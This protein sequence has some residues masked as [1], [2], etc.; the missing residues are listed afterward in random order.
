[1]KSK[2][3]WWPFIQRHKLRV[4]AIIMMGLLSSYCTLLLPLS[5]G[6][7]MEITA[8]GGAGKTKALHLLGI[9]LPDNLPAFFIFFFVVLIIKFISNWGYCFLA[10]LLGE[11]FAAALQGSL[12]N[13][14]LRR[15]YVVNEGG[16]K[17]SLL[18][19]FT[20]DAKTIQLLLT[21]GI[22][23]FVSDFLFFIM[24]LYVLFRLQPMLTLYVIM[25]ICFF[26]GIQ[27]LYNHSNKPLFAEKRKRQSALLNATSAMLNN[28]NE[29]TNEQQNILNRKKQK[30]KSTL[31]RFHIRK[32]FLKALSPFMLYLML[33]AIMS[34]ISLETGSGKPASGEIITYILLLMI[35]FPTLRNLIRIEN[36]W[37]VGNLAAEKYIK[38]A[39][40]RPEKTEIDGEL[41]KNTTNNSISLLHSGNTR[42]L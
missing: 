34:I 11:S 23:G 42:Q 10:S 41:L 31:F 4:A 28:G 16:Q 15:K 14:I 39:V 5:I 35:L 40:D 3:V 12:F 7:F 25:M 24:A 22:V 26:Y 33:A 36:T 18:M 32:S 9:H 38:A 8:G 2:I 19:S 17:A 1:M 29:L 20:S 37:V 13:Y 6:K 27:R 21:K 30:L